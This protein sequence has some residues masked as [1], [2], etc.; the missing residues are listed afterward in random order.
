MT[1][2]TLVLSPTRTQND[3]PACWSG[4]EH[5]RE[6]AP[7]QCCHAMVSPPCQRSS[8]AHA[9][10]LLSQVRLP[11]P[12]MSVE[13]AIYSAGGRVN[14]S[15]SGRSYI[16]HDL[17]S[18]L[19]CACHRGGCFWHGPSPCSANLQAARSRRLLRLYKSR[20]GHGV[21]VVNRG[22]RDSE[23]LGNGSYMCA[24]RLVPA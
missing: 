7:G 21:V 3:G 9:R 16:G 4:P 15:R 11:H 1:M 13:G 18:L 8:A 24:A 17:C 2:K 20:G 23:P 6:S 10:R 14:I 22:G 12:R 5:L 19:P